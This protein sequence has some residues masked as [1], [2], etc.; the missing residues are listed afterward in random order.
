[1]RASSS[2]VNK[3]GYLSSNWVRKFGKDGLMERLRAIVFGSLVAG[4]L[5]ISA[6]PALAGDW[7]KPDRYHRW[8][9]ARGLRRDIHND[10]A[11]LAYYYRD[12]ERNRRHL[13]H[14]RRIGANRHQIARDQRAIQTDL[15]R[16]HSIR[17]DIWQ[18]RRQLGGHF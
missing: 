5:L 18:D 12:L 14:D 11:D 6:G 10:R 13:D 7:H 2:P 15:D 3:Y 9:D 1:M 17:G 4:S 16:I 8:D